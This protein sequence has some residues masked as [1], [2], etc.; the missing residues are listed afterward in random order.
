MLLISLS[1]LCLFCFLI[2]YRTQKK[3]KEQLFKAID[4][5][6]DKHLPP[7]YQEAEYRRLDRVHKTTEWVKLEDLPLYL[8]QMV[9]TAEDASFAKNDGIMWHDTF[10]SLETCLFQWHR[11]ARGASTIT[12]QLIKNLCFASFKRSYKRKIFELLYART[13]TRHLGKKKILETYLNIIEFGEGVF[14]IQAAAQYHFHKQA[15]ALTFEEAFYIVSIIPAPKSFPLGKFKSF[16]AKHKERIRRDFLDAD[17]SFFTAPEIDAMLEHQHL[18]RLSISRSWLTKNP[19][20]QANEKLNVQG[21][22]IHSVGVPVADASCFI[23][24]WDRKEFTRACVHAFIDAK[25]GNV[26]QCL[27]W[28]CRA[29]HCGGQANNT[30]IGIELCEPETIRYVD[31]HHWEDISPEKTKQTVDFTYRSAVNICAFLCRRFNLNPLADGVIL[32]HS[33]AHARKW[34]S[35]H[36]DVEHLWNPLGLTTNHF[37]QEVMATMKSFGETVFLTSERHIHVHSPWVQLRKYVVKRTSDCF[38]RIGRSIK[39]R[40]PQ[41]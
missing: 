30:H 11:K 14:G 4:R 19:C 7:P 31:S 23:R 38:R 16:Y 6:L 20:F 39:K 36:A 29:W 26:H 40:L 3:W 28:Q 17:L 18:Q 1:S 41:K 13:L 32:S 33:E 24:Q 15:S 8:L 5:V 2:L 34:A 9:V 10:H 12:Q 37:R 27:P 22:M 25:T 35:N 21:I